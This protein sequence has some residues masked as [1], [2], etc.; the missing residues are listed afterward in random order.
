[1]SERARLHKNLGFPD[2]PK[3]PVVPTVEEATLGP[4]ESHDFP[5]MDFYGRGEGGRIHTAELLVPVESARLRSDLGC[6]AIHLA[7]ITDRGVEPLNSQEERFK[8]TEGTL[9]GGYRYMR[10]AVEVGRSHQENLP[11]WVRAS[12]VWLMNQLQGIVS[13]RFMSKIVLGAICKFACLI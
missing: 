13:G 12:T 5:S 3:I 10:Q 4:G 2:G 11:A 8:W 7:Y 9:S 1:M 6:D